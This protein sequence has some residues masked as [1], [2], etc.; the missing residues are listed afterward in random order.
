MISPIT[1]KASLLDKRINKPD[2]ATMRPNCVSAC[3][4]FGAKNVTYMEIQMDRQMKRQSGEEGSQK[5][6][7]DSV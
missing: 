4:D 6:F 5:A 7:V 1:V 2:W 3:I